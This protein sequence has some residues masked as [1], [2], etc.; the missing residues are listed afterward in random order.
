M[1]GNEEKVSVIRV[2]TD[3]NGGEQRKSVRHKS[4]DGQKWPE[5]RK[6]CPP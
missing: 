4:D 1:A 6:K 5:T 3:R 2:M